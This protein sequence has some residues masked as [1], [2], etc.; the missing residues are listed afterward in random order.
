MNV[1]RDLATLGWNLFF[2]QQMLASEEQFLKA[3]IAAHHGSQVIVFTVAGENAIPIQL[4]D[5]CGELAVGDWILLNP[6]DFARSE[7]S[8]ESQ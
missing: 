8:I 3:R 6:D 1:I 7:D 2:E 4:T 5:A